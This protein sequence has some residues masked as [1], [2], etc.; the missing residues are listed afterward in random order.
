MIT[1]SKLGRN[2]RLGNQMFQYAAARAA[3]FNT[4]SIFAIPDNNDLIQMFNLNCKTYNLSFNLDAICRLKAF[5]ENGFN[6]NSSFNTIQDNTDL[7]GYFQSE[8]YFKT[9]RNEILQDFTFKKEIRH[10]SET[11]ISSIRC[12]TRQLVSV[13]IRR[14]DY[15]DKQQYHPL[16][17]PE[18]YRNAMQSFDNCDFVIF[19]D[20]IKWCKENLT[21]KQTI[22][23]DLGEQETELCAMTLCDHN[24]IAN[25]SF[26]WW[27]AWLN[28]NSNKK[29]I[30]PKTWFGNNYSNLDTTDIY[31]ENWK[32]L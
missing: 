4:N 26:S 25:S 11:F 3:S 9:I 30:A 10:K 2:G 18:Y 29:V 22:F 7:F 32:I 19:S 6:Y 21:E 1:Y 12:D 28:T 27:G 13:H 24:I 31:C 5:N 17:T 15:V 23:S 14:G 20:D 16:C 8:R